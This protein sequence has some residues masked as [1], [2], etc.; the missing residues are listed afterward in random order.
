MVFYSLKL[1]TCTQ[2]PY[3]SQQI[4]AELKWF[5]ASGHTEKTQLKKKTQ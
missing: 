3:N 1:H 4:L 2:N 5:T